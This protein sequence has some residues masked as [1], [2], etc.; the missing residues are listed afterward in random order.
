MRKHEGFT[1]GFIQGIPSLTN[2]NEIDAF[3]PY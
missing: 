1:D 3:D 2:L